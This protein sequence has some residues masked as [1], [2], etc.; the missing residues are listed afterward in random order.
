MPWLNAYVGSNPSV[1]TILLLAQ[2]QSTG[3]GARRS[4]VA[5]RSTIQIQ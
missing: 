1:P 3:F 2:V 4:G 5:I